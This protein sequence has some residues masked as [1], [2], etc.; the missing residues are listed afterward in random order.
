M[1]KKVTKDTRKNDAFLKRAIPLPTKITIHGKHNHPLEIFR[2]LGFLRIHP[3][4]RDEFLEHFNNG[5]GP[6]DASQIHEDK[7]M[8]EDDGEIKIANAAIN[9][10]RRTI[11]HLHDKWLL[12]TFGK[13]WSSMEP[14]D[15]LK[16]KLETYKK[17]GVEIHIDDADKSRWCILVVTPTMKR[18]QSLPEAA[19]I[20]VTDST[21]SCDAQRGAVPL[22]ILIH[23]RLDGIG[24]EQAYRMFAT[25]YPNGF[26][27]K[28]YPEVFMTDNCDQEKGALST[29]WPDALQFLCHFHVGQAE[30]RWLTE[31]KHAV[32]QDKRQEL[33][34]LFQ[35]I[36]YAND[37][38]EYEGAKENFKENCS[39][40]KY[41]NRVEEFIKREKEW[42]KIFRSETTYRGHNTNNFAEASIRVIKD[43]IL[44]RTKA[45]N[46]CAMVDFMSRVW[47][48]HTKKRLL[49]Y[50]YDRESKH[51]LQY[52]RLCKKMSPELA[53]KI[54]IV[55]E[56]LYE[57]PSGETGELAYEVNS[58][59]GWCSCPAGKGG[60][61][62]KH[63]ALVY[64][65]FQRGFP[66]TPAVTYIERYK[67]ALL[68]LGP[69]KCPD[70]RFFL[71]FD[72]K[73]NE[74][75][76]ML[77]SQVGDTVT[78]T[79]V[80]NEENE[81]VPVEEM[82]AENGDQSTHD[83]AAQAQVVDETM[84][85][86]IEEMREKLHEQIDRLDELA[87]EGNKETYHRSLKVM[88][89]NLMKP[90]TPAQATATFMRLKAG[91]IQLHHQG[92]KRARAKGAKR[93]RVGRPMKPG[94][95]G[96]TKPLTT[97][98]KAALKRRLAASVR[99]NKTH[100][101]THHRK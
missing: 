89:R 97:A 2:S 23:N 54:V 95:N 57:V 87:K 19:E 66:N 16:E 28:T 3:D 33:M 85:M 71:D 92:E 60:A 52:D 43:N 6:A 78:G 88:V 74:S 94:N 38:E 46:C 15:K 55:E 13:A 34:R 98:A 65:K 20:V 62:C 5:H 7:L 49:H 99:A 37:T 18:A 45:Y 17:E 1:I 69:D 8:L 68:A 93:Q 14:L 67:L 84:A 42:A 50:A 12:T 36:M 61:F 72:E 81:L 41:G 83:L 39:H 101:K 21:G 70:V 64:S 29:I 53:E 58:L 9:P 44:G 80:V 100:I 24:Y 22:C 35:Q 32:P 86:E 76:E 48:G 4:I 10:K 82:S 47:E 59:V 31:S 77:L 25:H 73:I 90:S 75:E 27:N 30:W 91:S 96:K 51:R 63:Q 26:G 56:D 11:Y 40:E 79:Y